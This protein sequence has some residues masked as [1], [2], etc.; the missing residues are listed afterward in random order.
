MLENVYKRVLFP[1]PGAVFRCP[2]EASVENIVA[3]TRYSP[4]I[5]HTAV[6]QSTESDWYQ[7]NY[8]RW[9]SYDFRTADVQEV[10]ST[11]HY[12][13]NYPGQ[14]SRARRSFKVA[15]LIDS[16]AIFDKMERLQ[17]ERLANILENPVENGF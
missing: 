13:C 9:Y 5:A 11:H 16:Q 10:L 1:F 8:P 4:E 3:R 2:F 12:G 14:K 7:P 15:N 6:L 17:R